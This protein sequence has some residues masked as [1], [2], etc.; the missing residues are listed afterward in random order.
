MKL[1]LCAALIAMLGGCVAEYSGHGYRGGYYGHAGYLG[2]GYYD[3]DGHYHY[4][5][6]DRDHDRD[7][8]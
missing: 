4:Y 6:H 2:R 3:R 8:R 1:L 7:Y 5:D